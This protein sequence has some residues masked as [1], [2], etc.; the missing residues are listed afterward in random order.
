MLQISL[1]V[2]LSLGH[3]LRSYS[4]LPS[5]L[6]GLF[7]ST[8]STHQ[9]QKLVSAYSVSQLFIYLTFSLGDSGLGFP[10]Q[11]NLLSLSPSLKGPV[12][13]SVFH[14][15]TGSPTHSSVHL[16]CSHSLATGIQWTRCSWTLHPFMKFYCKGSMSYDP[17]DLHSLPHPWWGESW[18]VQW[19]I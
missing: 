4:C 6:P 11:R 12:D 10:L 13:I 14:H 5:L 19:G 17:K 1:Q 18:D 3:N 7:S 16:W 2:R 9:L 15:W 8:F